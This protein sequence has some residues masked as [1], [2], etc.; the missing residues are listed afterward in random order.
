M[1]ITA[2]I[3]SGF[4]SILYEFIIFPIRATFPFHLILL[5]LIV[6]VTESH[7]EACLESWEFYPL[8]HNI[9]SHSCAS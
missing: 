3:P 1:S 7:V 5:N 9:F 4:P 6:Q 8:H 2:S